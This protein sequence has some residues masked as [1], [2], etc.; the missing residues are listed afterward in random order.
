MAK[1]LKS[2]RR[3]LD[4]AALMQIAAEAGRSL[5]AAIVRQDKPLVMVNVKMAEDSTVALAQRRRPESFR[6]NVSA[7][8]CERREYRLLRK[9]WKIARRVGGQHEHTP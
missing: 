4:A 7:A 6:S 9:I 2:A 8:L 3:T 5:P 1:E